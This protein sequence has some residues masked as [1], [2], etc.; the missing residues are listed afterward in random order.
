MK[1]DKLSG[2][3]SK[4]KKEKTIKTSDEKRAIITDTNKTEETVRMCL[5]V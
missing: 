1:I 5:K 2:K 4:W 3:L